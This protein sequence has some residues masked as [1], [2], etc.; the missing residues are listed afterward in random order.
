MNAGIHRAS[1]SVPG[2]PVQEAVLLRMLLMAG[3]AVIE[4]IE[5]ILKPHGLSDSD[6][7]TL[8]MVYTAPG[9]RT[10]PSEL[11]GYAQQS[12][13]N[14]TRITN[15]LV[16]QGFVTRASSDED[17]RRVEL[18]ITPLGRRFVRKLLPTLFPRIHGAFASLSATEQKTLEQLLRKVAANI[19]QLIGSDSHP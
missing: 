10:S 5:H 9:G 14:M 16:Q 2:L 19:D 18:S 6:F 7:R 4:E 11:C 12:P 3:N 13:T 8:M 1:E 17:R 15:V